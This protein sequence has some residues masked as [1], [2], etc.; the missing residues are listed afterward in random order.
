MLGFE[1]D[2]LRQAFEVGERWGG[3]ARGGSG[4]SGRNET[5]REFGRA[6]LLRSRRARLRCGR[7]GFRSPLLFET[8]R[9]ERRRDG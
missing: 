7:K 8:G 2:A 6:L 5:S 3:G 1:V 9:A 4:A